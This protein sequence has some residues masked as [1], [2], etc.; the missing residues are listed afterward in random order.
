MEDRCLNNWWH[1]QSKG[2]KAMKI[3]LNVFIKEYFKSIPLFQI[4][5]KAHARWEHIVLF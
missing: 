3:N 4:E 2:E 1:F 5:Y